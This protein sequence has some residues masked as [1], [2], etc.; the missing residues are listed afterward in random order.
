MS[1]RGSLRVALAALFAASLIALSVPAYADSLQDC[2]NSGTSQ[3]G[4]PP[5]CVDNGD[6]TYSPVDNS[7]PGFGNDG[8]GLPGE[9]L[10][11]GFGVVIVVL[12]IGT[13][14]WKVSAARKIATQSG[15]D[16]DTA[17]TMA[18]LTNHGL[19]ETYLLANLP[20][21]GQPATPAKVDEPAADKAS[22]AARLT[23]LKGLLDGGMITQTEY[24]E[25]RKGI[26]A[27]V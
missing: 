25:R 7:D 2:L 6:G 27:D 19:E 20:K 21:L 24:D 13:A 17:S 22:V 14:M 4:T 26:I 23:E 5:D 10:F 3:D 18:L 12:A 16:P 11:I 15:L 9:G 8:G 1:P